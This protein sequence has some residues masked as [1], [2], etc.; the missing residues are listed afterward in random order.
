MQNR[1]T[2]K[3]TKEAHSIQE[4]VCQA[5]S[6]TDNATCT[7]PKLPLSKINQ[8]LP[9][10]R[11]ARDRRFYPSI[12]I[13]RFLSPSP[14]QEFS[15]LLAIPLFSST[16]HL[17]RLPAIPRPSYA[18]SSSRPLYLTSPTHHR[19][20]HHSSHYPIH[21]AQ[22]TPSYRRRDQTDDIRIKRAPDCTARCSFQS[23]QPRRVDPG[24]EAHC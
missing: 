13:F 10:K 17:T 1:T 9:S 20:V 2:E 16:K 19:C 8:A 14:S 5:P 6:M 24:A 7:Y 21:A 3:A 15:P 18:S 22:H 23:Q 11:R 4:I 12:P